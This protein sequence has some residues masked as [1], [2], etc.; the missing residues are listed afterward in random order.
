MHHFFFGTVIRGLGKGKDFGFPTANIKLNDSELCIEK[1]V[2]AVSVNIDNQLYKG[3]LYAGTRPTLEMQE[4]T[5][6][7]HILEFNKDIYNQHISCQ[8]LHKIRDEINFNSIEKLI[9]QLHQ[10]KEKVYNF[11]N[12]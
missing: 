11:F 4:I 2:Y 5:I 1:G 9:E 12:H 8:I 6:E 3:M 10:D 7:I